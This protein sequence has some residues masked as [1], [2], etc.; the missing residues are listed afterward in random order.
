MNTAR[1]TSIKGNALIRE[2][3][4][5]KGRFYLFCI[6]M[7]AV[8]FMAACTG[9][10]NEPDHEKEP[11]KNETGHYAVVYDFDADGISK[12]RNNTVPLNDDLS[13]DTADDPAKIIDAWNILSEEEKRIF[14]DIL[15]S[16]GTWEKIEDE[17]WRFSKCPEL[18]IYCSLRHDADSF[19]MPF[20]CLYNGRFS[21]GYDFEVETH[22]RDPIC[23][24]TETDTGTD[25]CLVYTEE[26]PAGE[27]CERT[28]IPDSR[29]LID[30][31]VLFDGDGVRVTAVSL[32]RQTRL[33]VLRMLLKL[34]NGT[35]RELSVSS[36][37]SC[38]ND[39]MVRSSLD[40]TV[41]PGE[42][43]EVYLDF[44]TGSMWAYLDF[45]DVFH[46][47]YKDPVDPIG[48]IY[49]S[50][51]LNDKSGVLAETGLISIPVNDDHEDDGPDDPDDCVIYDEE[52]VSLTLGAAT[53]PGSTRYPRLLVTVINR[54]GRDIRI[55]LTDSKINC[56]PRDAEFEGAVLDGR[57][58]SD[59]IVFD[60]EEGLSERV[61]IVDPELRFEIR[62][63][64]TGEL[65]RDTGVIYPT[66]DIPD[67]I[68]EQRYIY[69]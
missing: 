10:D 42:E 54:S 9:R 24:S 69:N 12:K 63:M 30:E 65:I 52:G 2:T 48:Q 58:L 1:S 51:L 36:G 21:I 35:D 11:D 28:V 44:D 4:M 45:E 59:F 14:S 43:K 40:E 33:G 31:Q 13:V 62:D 49:V 53:D 16:P 27:A 60:Y 18:G 61:D 55:T 15:D 7:S 5:R 8:V 37:L 47:G 64:K 34:E 32:K 68:G 50:F 57:Q 67:H 29:E 26:I 39:A 66:A 6:L 17:Y 20:A 23:G 46:T 38:I 3:V 25:S 56:T 41:L 19:L 22:Y